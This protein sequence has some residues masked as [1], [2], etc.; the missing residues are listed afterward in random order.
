MILQDLQDYINTNFSDWAG[1]IN[2]VETCCS[3][4]TTTKCYA[5]NEVDINKL[6]M[7]ILSHDTG[8]PKFT[9]RFDY[10]MKLVL[11][12]FVFDRNEEMVNYKAEM[13]LRSLLYGLYQVPNGQTTINNIVYTVRS[14]HHLGSAGIVIGRS[15]NFLSGV[16]LEIEAYVNNFRR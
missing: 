6:P 7:M 13:Y 4:K 8:E 11:T 16:E 12:A 9:T 2:G 1:E 14:Y 3:I 10:D 5:V 15:K